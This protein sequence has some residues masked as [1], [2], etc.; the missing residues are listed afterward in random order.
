MFWQ[1]K[2]CLSTFQYAVATTAMHWMKQLSQ[3]NVTLYP[4]Q[5]LM[6]T[7]LKSP[8]KVCKVEKT[9]FQSF[10]LLVQ[11]TTMHWMKQLSHSNVTLCPAQSLK[12]I[13]HNSQIKVWAVANLFFNLSISCCTHSNALDKT[14]VTRNH[15]IMSCTIAHVNNA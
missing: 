13:L 9:V 1:W 2:S 4:A 11:A 15:D 12:Q 7:I 14:A 6:K 5:S 3:A 10:N 8:I